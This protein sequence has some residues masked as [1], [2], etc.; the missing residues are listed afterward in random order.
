MKFFISQKWKIVLCLFHFEFAREPFASYQHLETSLECSASYWME[1]L[2]AETR[3]CHTAVLPA[4]NTILT[5]EI[6]TA[7]ISNM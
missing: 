1:Y 2:E 3:L 4:L 7:Q 5:I 6:N